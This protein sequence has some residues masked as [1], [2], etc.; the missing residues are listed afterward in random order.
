[1]DFDVVHYYI[2]F[3]TKVNGECPAMRWITDHKDEGGLAR[4]MIRCLS[5]LGLECG[6]IS[7][8]TTKDIDELKS[9]A[10]QVRVYY[11]I[12]DNFALILNA[13]F[14]KDQKNDI[15]KSIEYLEDFRRR[16]PL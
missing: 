16:R 3:Y 11:S 8:L 15:K 14:K 12:M 10:G 4:S 9:K 1:M 13:G 7:G 6:F 2:Y 5:N